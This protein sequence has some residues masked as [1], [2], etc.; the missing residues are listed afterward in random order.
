MCLLLLIV[1]VFG[2]RAENAAPDSRQNPSSKENEKGRPG[3]LYIY[4][5]VLQVD[6]EAGESGESEDDKCGL[7]RARMRPRI[8]LLYEL[9]EAKRHFKGAK[10]YARWRQRKVVRSGDF[11]RWVGT[12]GYRIPVSRPNA[13][14]SWLCGWLV[15]QHLPS[16]LLLLVWALARRGEQGFGNDL[17]DLRPA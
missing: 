3:C 1:P 17:V 9:G 12:I 2:T 13:V 15:I 8:S 7:Q 10:S 16:L 14:A 6:G 11:D 5:C 4:L